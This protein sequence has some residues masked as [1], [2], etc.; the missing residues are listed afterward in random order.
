MLLAAEGLAAE[1]RLDVSGDIKAVEDGLEVRVDLTNRGDGEAA[2]VAVQG[3]L[4]GKWD[5]G[6]VDAGIPPGGKAAVSLRFPV[7]VT[8]P[9]V[10]PVVLRLEY[11]TRPT[12]GVVSQRAYLLL[13]LGANPPPAVRVAAA[14]MRL[15]DRD[16][17]KVRLESADGAEHRARLR[18][19]TPRGLNAES[20]EA[21]VTVPARGEA[22]V[23]VPVRRG[24]VPRP[25]RQGLLLV[26]GT[27]DGEQ[28][29]TA[30]ATTVVDVAADP[31]WLPRVR[32][33]LAVVAFALMVAAVVLEILAVRR[34]SAGA[35]ADAAPPA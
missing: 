30:V 3:E 11:Q 1:V 24:S 18:V 25:S 10:H 9:G 7:E 6:R 12:P 16:L 33:P 34:E 14:E 29:T 4:L 26:A 13:S 5:E 28:E 31:A 15:H 20:P 8:R 2:E 17:L 21:E 27:A 23:E 35:P 32:R 19:L 22:V